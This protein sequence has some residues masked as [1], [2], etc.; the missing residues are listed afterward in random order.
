MA[1]LVSSGTDAF[2]SVIVLVALDLNVCPCHR[3]PH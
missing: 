2:Q 1:S 3:V